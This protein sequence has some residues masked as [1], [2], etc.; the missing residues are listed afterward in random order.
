MFKLNRKL[1]LSALALLEKHEQML[2]DECLTHARQLGVVSQR[3][4]DNWEKTITEEAD[5][6]ISVAR[7]REALRET[8]HDLKKGQERSLAVT[9]GFRY[10][11]SSL[12]LRDCWE[13]L[14][15]D[16]SH[17][18]RLHL[19]TGTITADG[20]RV[21]SR[22]EKVKYE[23]Q[24]AAYVSADKTDSHQRIISLSENYGHLLLAVFHSHISRG[25][26][27]TSPSA[28]DLSFLQ[29]MA[30]I[31]CDC[32]GGIF[33][34]DGYARFFMRNK[35]FA[36]DVYGS[37]IKKIEEDAAHKIFQVLEVNGHGWKTI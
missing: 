1:N 14:K 36:I 4:V 33:S 8:I 11:I 13:Y 15:S 26:A 23:K 28:I 16:P 3:L 21:L 25:V 29:R 10:Q 19:V 20:T 37:G 7:G 6:I 22:I 31:G 5:F 27:A 32:L 18:E 35:D 24:G 9:A 12:F 34:L 30:Q 2:I 17:N